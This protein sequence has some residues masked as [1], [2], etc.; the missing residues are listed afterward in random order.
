[1]SELPPH[2]KYYTQQTKDSD[3]ESKLASQ[4]SLSDLDDTLNT[5][6]YSRPGT[7]FSDAGNWKNFGNAILNESFR[8]AG[9]GPHKNIMQNFLSRLDRH[10]NTY[11]PTNTMNY[12]YTFITRPRFNLTTGN[13]LQHPVT[14][15][16][17]NG[18]QIDKN[19]V[20]FMIRM[21]MDTRL[22]SGQRVLGAELT[23]EDVAIYKAAQS[24][25]LL[26][27]SNPFFTPLCNGLR[28][29]SGWPDFNL[30]TATMG[31][32]FHSGDFTFVKGSDMLIRTTEL[33]LEFADVQGSII[34][35]CMFYWCLLMALQAKGVI[36]AYP[37]DVYEQRLN[38]TVSIYRFITDATRR[39]I[40]WWSKATGCFPKSAPIGQLFNINQGEVTISSAKQFSIPFT[41]NVIEYNN[42]SI[43]FDFRQL[44]RNYVSDFDNINK[45][46]IV[47]NN[48][49]TGTALANWN[50]IGLPDVIDGDTSLELVW[51][52]NKDKYSDN[53]PTGE[54]AGNTSSIDKS[55]AELYNE[56]DKQINKFADDLTKNNKG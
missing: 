10:G 34:L 17:A 21:L 50:Y 5:D 54:Y 13:L 2:T 38:Y 15:L 55:S 8:S 30:E 32:D 22:C 23:N 42:P 4:Y 18:N 53:W 1:M 43:L 14:A 9:V 39:N 36:Q 56:R 48:P 27:T 29:I 44:I 52:T 51:R 11:A 40:L 41:A 16:L 33:S 25:G 7:F 47:P 6:K 45:W 12:G 26:D 49:I 28:G 20:S 3:T 19:S 31:E 46:P 37:D 35:S 24:S